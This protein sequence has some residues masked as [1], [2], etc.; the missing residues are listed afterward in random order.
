MLFR[1]EIVSADAE[2]LKEGVLAVD[3][4]IGE[5]SEGIYAKEWD[6]NGEKATLAVEKK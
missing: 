2:T 1:S 6:L 4:V 5:A 3:V